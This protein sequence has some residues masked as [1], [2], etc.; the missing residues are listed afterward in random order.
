MDFIPLE[1]SAAQ[2]KMVSLCRKS[3]PAL[4]QRLLAAPPKRVVLSGPS[5]FLG[6]TVSAPAA[7]RRRLP[8]ALAAPSTESAMASTAALAA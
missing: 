7:P 8:R 1:Q 6:A 3:M 5:G 4:M 2:G